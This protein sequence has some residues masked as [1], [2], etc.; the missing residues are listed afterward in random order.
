MAPRK[1]SAAIKS[2]GATSSKA[3]PLP[4]WVKGGAEKPAAAPI[5]TDGQPQLFPAGAKTPLALLNERIQKVPGWHKPDVHAR[6]H[7]DG[8]TCAVTLRKDNR[9]DRSHP[10]T[11]RMEPREDGA[12]LRCATAL[13]A[14]HWGATY[15]L[16]RLFN[17][18]GLQRVLPPGPRE[19]WAKL[20]HVKAAA[21]PGDAW[22][23]ESDPFD[24][25]LR[26]DAERAARDKARQEGDTARAH[27]RAPVLSRAWMR[28]PEV[29]MAP[30]LR[31]L[32]ERIVRARLGAGGGGA[33]ADGG[34]GEGAV[35][36]SEADAAG[37][38]ADAD[39]GAETGASARA[40]DLVG[41][42]SSTGASPALDTPALENALTKLGVRP[43]YARRVVAWLAHARETYADRAQMAQLHAAHPLLASV[44]ALPDMDAAVEYLVL[45][46]PE[47]DLPPRLRPTAAAESFVTGAQGAQDPLV[48]RWTVE[49]L[50]KH[51]GFPR[52]NVVQALAQIRAAAP[53]LTLGPREGVLLDVLLAA[54]VGEAPDA[55]A[56]A[57]ASVRADGPAM[58]AAA[59]PTPE[60]DRI[61][62]DDFDIVL[63]AWDGA[64]VY[65]RVALH[66][67]SRY[68][69]P[70]HADALPSVY[71]TG[72][73]LPA[74]LRLA[75]TQ[76]AQR[77]LRSET[78]R[79]AMQL[80]GGVLL[81]LGEELRAVMPRLLEDPPPPD[82]V[83]EHL[84]AAAPRAPAQKLMAPRRAD[85]GPRAPRAPRTVRA[86]QRDARVDDALRAAQA[87]LH[88]SAAYREEMAPA[89]AAL[90]AHAA[91]ETLLAELGMH[92]ILLVAGETGCGKTTQV[93]QFVL[94]DAIA[95]GCGSTCSIV[96]TQPRRVS[97]LGVAARVAAERGERL[98]GGAV[99][100][101]A[102]VG[103]AIRGERRASR[104]CRLLF[105]TTGV[106]LRRLAAG[107]DPALRGLSH[108]VVD[109][110]HERSTDSDLLLLLVRDVLARNPDLRVVLMSATID[111]AAFQAYFGGAPCVHI[112]GRTFPVA[113]H[114]LEDVVAQTGFVSRA[115][116]ARADERTDA[117][118]ERDRV[119]AAAVPTLRQLVA[120]DRTD[121]TVLAAA[122]GLGAAHARALD[123]TRALRGCA[124]VLVFCPGVGEIRQAMD[125]IAAL[126]LPELVVL[127]LHASLA[128]SEQRRVF[129][130]L[131]RGQRKVIVATN[132]AE[133]SITI[134][135][136]CVVVDTGRVRE[137]QYDAHAG[138]TRLLETW[139]SRAACKQRAGRAGRT[140]PGVCYRLYTR[141]MECTRQRAQTLP[142]MLRTPLEGVVLQA[143]AVQPDAD[144]HA[145]LRRAL[146][147]PPL[148]ALAA[149]H[150]RLVV[151][152]A[153][154]A[155]GGY[156]AALT[157]LGRHMADLPLDVRHA[158]LLVLAC[159]FGCVEPLLHIVALLAA[160]P[161]THASARDA[162][163][164]AARAHFL[165]AQSDLLSLAHLYAHYLALRR[166]HRGTRAVRDWCDAHGLAPAALQDVDMTRTALLRNLEELRLV[167][168]AYVRTWRA[169][170]ARWP[171]A[172][173]AHALDAH[174]MNTNLLRALLLAALWPSVARVDQPTAKFSASAAG[175]VQRDAA[176]RELHY[177]DEHAGRVFLHPSSL[178][179]H[180]NKYKSS[181]VAVCNKSGNATRTY[182]R[183]V[184]ESPL[185]ALLLFGGPLYVD[186]GIGG[187]TVSTGTRASADAWVKLRASGRI[188][189]LCRQLRTLLDQALAAGVDDPHRLLDAEHQ[190]VVGVMVALV[191]GDGV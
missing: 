97:A 91:R 150:Q 182:L 132:V 170:G 102:L 78:L 88:S 3:A 87:Q 101:G 33:V 34:V 148:D 7:N 21:P 23:W 114:Y 80:G 45:Y 103:Y 146:D 145:F 49:K 124:A 152:G 187:I 82:A 10:F 58:L 28:A 81:V 162:D 154:H 159:L 130:P 36:G 113:E 14:K 32:V 61:G 20:E 68:L 38:D 22:K 120:A 12:Q 93:P 128:A 143:K 184:T 40:P 178:L 135:D 75:L 31:E 107:S 174:S 98:E 85:A 175:A 106:L 74:F 5:R 13:E 72:A 188:A 64:D 183:D 86:L 116:S 1:K 8:F 131:G 185:Y 109:E 9:Q 112:P 56:C 111:A 57:C 125:A 69:H 147:P 169:D 59:A 122:V 95:R 191:T 173:G 6:Q 96:V 133:T 44:L 151:A 115:P 53:D 70:A 30:A 76:A 55:A 71:V 163:T 15:V 92:R 186:H 137:A 140:M 157:P 181:Y 156:A 108:V 17:H 179:F 48:D 168:A 66:P 65:L 41:G 110:V 50:C 62:A 176:S 63:G 167:D 19:Y 180:A 67:G 139:A 52:A 134:A 4:D 171:R 117:L 172:A 149:T 25:A 142:E 35:M 26:R 127:P 54:L 138:V 2:S 84:V 99:A 46:T 90:P 51:A 100:D 43:G 39:A 166:E 165:L 47:Q 136:V 18:L 121:Y 77:A 129:Q 189:V 42:R 24:A 141:G 60:R 27:P 105:T 160:R 104:A 153:L 37:A 158:K 164:A 16:F 11:V 89:R 177:F 126:R 29:R 144:V 118:I 73:G 79:E 190:E 94:D 119:P 155:D 83:M 161:I 123:G